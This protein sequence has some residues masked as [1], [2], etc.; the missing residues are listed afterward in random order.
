MEQ[1]YIRLNDGNEI[2][3]MGLGVFTIPEGK[4]TEDA[5]IAALDCGYRHIDTAHAYGNERSVGKAVR[6]SGVPRDEVWITSK[7]WPTE[8]GEP[9]DAIDRML[10][11][12]DMGRVDLLLLHQQVGDYMTAY[13]GM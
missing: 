6:A 13:K 9:A 4:P 5:C 1:T 10:K 7:L 12:L 3:Q 8:Y 11:R 2:P